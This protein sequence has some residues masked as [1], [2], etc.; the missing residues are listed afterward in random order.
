[1][2]GKKTAKKAQEDAAKKSAAADLAVTQAAQPTPLQSAWE[3]SNLDFLDWE[4]GKSGPV[5][6][7]K[8]PGLG[9]ARSLFSYG[10]QK[11]ENEKQGIGA[12]RLGLNATSP[13]AA[14][15]LAEQAQLRREQ[16]AAGQL[17]NAVAARS[18]EAHGSVMPLSSLNLSR[19]MGIAG[20]RT[21]M[22][23][24]AQQRAED[25]RRNSGIM[26]TTIGRALG[27][28][29]GE[30]IGKGLAG[31][32]PFAKD[33]GRIGARQP[34]VGAEEGDEL[35]FTDD[36]RVKVLRGGPRLFADEQPLTVIPHEQS[37]VL[38]AST[39]LGRLRGTPSAPAPLWTQVRQGLGPA[40][41]SPAP[42]DVMPTLT[43][44]KPEEL[45]LPERGE[46]LRPR[47]A[48]ERPNF[49]VLGH[50]TDPR[51]LG[52]GERARVA[53]PFEFAS[54]RLQA[55]EL[56]PPPTN[57][58]SRLGSIAK[59]A[60]RGFLKGGVLGAIFGAGSHALDNSA[61][62]RAEQAEMV[63]RD[64]SRV[65]NLSAL[66]DTRLDLEG[67]GV[68]NRLRGVQ[69]DDWEDRPERERLAAEA[70][71]KKAE[72]TRIL[73]LLRLHN[74]RELPPELV[75]EAVAAGVTIDP[76]AWADSASNQVSVEL[77]DPENPSQVR[78]VFVNKVTGEFSDVG[79]SRFQAPRDASGMTESERRVDSDRDSTR[80]L[81]RRLGEANLKRI[82]V[83]IA[84]ME[85][86]MKYMSPGAAREFNV[87]SKGIPE[88]IRSKRGELER[89]RRD[90]ASMVIDPAD[91]NPRIEALAAEIDALESS[92]EEARR[93]ALSGS[94]TSYSRPPAA[95]QKYTEAEVRA[96]A[97]AMG[98]P[99]DAAVQEARRLG[100]LK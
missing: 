84:R 92:F 53:K 32:V 51:N 96:R 99:E 95:T 61:D 91:A 97:R 81:Q 35:A 66:E 100:L 70:K 34:F 50:D 74:G 36:G 3:K 71:A 90:A 1:M 78:R 83:T 52:L 93:K 72:Q 6:V 76:G 57:R 16:D 86:E 48:E 98:R 68:L 58:N 9:V 22:S 38:A 46:A 5:D 4:S 37:K 89:L 39:S 7:M 65:G 88:A 27:T 49:G 14:A 63:A 43:E 59:G 30:T 31:R 18:A 42:P 10:R 69:A 25:L 15:N 29:F 80:E 64:R 47:M 2:F 21:G 11:Q 85:Q 55:A 67:K 33:G 17:E 77:A 8:A 79:L 56:A 41:D 75:A 40:P 73:S 20:L 54:K 24:Y 60:G 12:L 94:S 62:E 23:Q 28:S 87:V 26:S 13:E 45:P 19:S 82:G 44:Y